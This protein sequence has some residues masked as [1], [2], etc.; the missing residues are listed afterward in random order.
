MHPFDRHVDRVGEGEGEGEVSQTCVKLA[1][2][3]QSLS[4]G[5]SVNLGRIT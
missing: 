2:C 4:P 3:P 5:L 1:N